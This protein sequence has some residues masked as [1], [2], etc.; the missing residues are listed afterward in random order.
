MLHILPS[1]ANVQMYSW[2]CVGEQTGIPYYQPTN[3]P[4]KKNEEKKNEQ[5][6]GLYSKSAQNFNATDT[7]ILFI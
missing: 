1:D 7:N 3:K 4:T 5:S 6:I 2:T